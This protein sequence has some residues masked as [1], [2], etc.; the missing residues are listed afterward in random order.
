MT[1]PVPLPEVGE[2][3]CHGVTWA[4]GDPW[5]LLAPL[6][7]GPLAYADIMHQRL[8]FRVADAGRWCTGRYQF[9]DIVHVEALACPDRA[10][11]EQNGQCWRCA[12]QD[13]FRFAHQFHQGGH[14]PQALIRYM[15]QPHWLYLATFA[16]GATKVGT[17]AEPRKR[18]RLDEQGALFAT[19]LTKS[20]DGRAV[21]HL[22]DAL[23]R[24]LQLPQTIRAAAKLQA[25]ADLTDL[26]AARA[27]H[28]QHVTQA[29]D[30]LSDMNAPLVL[31]AWAPPAEGD[32]LRTADSERALYPHDLR[33]GEHGFTPISC[34]GSQVLAVLNR[35]EEMHYILDLGV[36]TGRRITLGPFSSP[37][38]AVQTP[39]F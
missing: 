9:A 18:S 25:Q 15:A 6:P 31:E 30:A 32:R 38:A 11:A 23:A 17:A 2:F 19:Y 26:A 34:V 27:T 14:A 4:T 33:E 5:L 12:S 3:V 13:D 1:M 8:G 20:P 22:E 39:L 16:D 24:R 10:P 21:R 28:E 36:L 29:A 7:R 35:D 37:R